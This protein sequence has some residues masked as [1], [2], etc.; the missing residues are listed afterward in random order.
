MFYRKVHKKGNIINS[1]FSILIFL[2]PKVNRIAHTVVEEFK[3]VQ[4]SRCP[5]NVYTIDEKYNGL[6]YHPFKNENSM[7]S[8]KVTNKAK[9]K[10]RQTDSN[11]KIYEDGPYETDNDENDGFDDKGK[12][13]L[14]TEKKTPKKSLVEAAKIDRWEIWEKIVNSIDGKDKLSKIVKYSMDLIIFILQS[15]ISNNK[16]SFFSLTKKLS[17][18]QILSK[19]LNFIVKKGNLL[20]L[21]SVFQHFIKIILTKLR[22]VSYQMGTYRYILRFGNSPFAIYKLIKSLKSREFVSKTLASDDTSEQSNANLPSM[23]SAIFKNALELYFTVCDELMLLYRFGIWSNVKLF[24]LI[25]KHEV[26]AW[27]FDIFLNLSDHFRNW[28]KLNNEILEKQIEWKI[29]QRTI[30]DLSKNGHHILNQEFTDLQRSRLFTNLD[31]ARLV[32]DLMANSTD[33]FNFNVSQGTYSLLSLSS[34]TFAMIKIWL[35]NKQELIDMQK[36]R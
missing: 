4:Q 9:Y 32:C 18:Y 17:T 23:N 12:L 15:L 19:I 25:S 29:R 24:E 34:A 21:S 5:M 16:L 13:N 33:F 22:A 2:S 8:N 3:T 7:L 14:V 10:N 1:F 26:Y 27:Q 35:K 6:N 36:N 30:P 28:Q 31:I 11:R 20:N